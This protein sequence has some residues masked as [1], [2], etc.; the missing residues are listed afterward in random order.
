MALTLARFPMRRRVG[1]KLLWAVAIFG[2][3]TVGFG[4]SQNF[5]LSVALLFCVGA[6]DMVSV[7]VRS[8][9][10]QLVSPHEMRGRVGA[11]NQ[12]FIGASN[13]L[14]DFESGVAA[15]LLGVV[16]AVVAGGLGTCVVVL[17]WAWRFPVLRRVDRLED[18]QA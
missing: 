8:T 13:E 5:P 17:L 1:P 12:M 14:G 7:V 15:Q 11:V 10:E 2:L 18:V 16:P 4:L 9:L 3:A 6:A